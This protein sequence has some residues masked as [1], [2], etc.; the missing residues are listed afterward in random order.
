MI[1]PGVNTAGASCAGVSVCGNM[2]AHQHRGD[3]SRR[4]GDTLDVVVVVFG[5]I[6]FS[7][8]VVVVVV[9]VTDVSVVVVVIGVHCFG[10]V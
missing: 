6:V 8:I 7:S 1:V 5:A 2:A 10:D 9:V 4:S 3:G